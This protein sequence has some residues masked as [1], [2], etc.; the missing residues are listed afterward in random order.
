MSSV[1]LPKLPTD[2]G[3]GIIFKELAA[4]R[5]A[6]APPQSEFFLPCDDHWTLTGPAHPPGG[7]PG[8][9]RL[10]LTRDQLQIY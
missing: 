9:S 7:L 3:D 5:P 2:P 10:L 8:A 6:R 1:L 4:L